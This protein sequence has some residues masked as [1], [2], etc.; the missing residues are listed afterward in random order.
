MK[1]GETLQQ[2]KTPDR[3]EQGLQERRGWPEKILGMHLLWAALSIIALTAILLPRAGSQL[4]DW[5]PGQVAT[6][7]VVMPMDVS[8]PDPEATDA[9]RE[10]ARESVLPVYDYEPKALVQL[11]EE[12]NSLF[13]ICRKPEGED[14]EFLSPV[15]RLLEGTQLSIE[16][17]MARVLIKSECSQELEKALQE[18]LLTLYSDRI[19]DDERAL[20]RRVAKKGLILRDLSTGKEI[21]ISPGDLDGIIDLRTELEGALRARLLEQGAVHR[22]WLRPII[23]FLNANIEANLFYDR[24]ETTERIRKAEESVTPRSQI[25][26]RGEILIRRGDRVG[27][28]QARVLQYLNRRRMDVSTYSNQAGIAGLVF[29][30]IA[31]WWKVSS[32]SGQVENRSRLSII[33]LLLVLFVGLNRLGLFL[34]EAVASSAGSSLLSDSRIYLWALPYASGAIT[35]NLLLGLQPALLFTASI[36]L[37]SGIMLG[38]SYQ[39]VVFAIGGGLVGALASQ[40]FKE[41]SAFSRVGVLIGLI[42][43][44]VILVLAL[45]AGWPEVWQKVGVE[46]IA[47]FFGGTFATG[48]ASLLLP[49]LENLAGIT[50]DIR[51]LELSNQNLPLL[52]RL[53]LEAPGTYQHSLAVGNL[54]EAGASAIGANSL[55]LRVCSYY[56]DVGKLVKPQYFVENQRGR[57]PHDSLLPSMSV[58]IIQSHVKEGLRLASQE[59][60][61]LPIRQGIATHHGTKLIRFFY[62]KALE[63][64]GDMDEKEKAKM[65]DIRES[66]YRYPGPKPHTKELGILLLADA[67]EAAARTIDSPTPGKIQGLVQK[68][69]SDAVDDGQLADSDLTFGEIDKI[70]SAFIWVL[71]N[72]YHS[73]IDYPGFDFNSPKGDPRRHETRRTADEETSAR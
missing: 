53:S 21:R 72:M 68:I 59:R 12:I 30:I 22:S 1:T 19:V 73:R 27:F 50:T 26:S 41:R 39:V 28:S 58:L 10:A 63:Q 45:W 51:L 37:L 24:A 5:E 48:I 32:R 47:G 54:A 40:Q 60:L 64:R 14:Q 49:I 13:Q 38:G 36:A 44:A 46:M 42:N 43:A 66:D 15:E 18:V 67:I 61:P 16:A 17:E 4:P 23:H 7:D 29:L 57:N 52:K 55:L 25:L 9:V 70:A 2:E 71:M 6:Y 3:I 34:A 8:L 20:E 62:T 65:G 56:H 11:S 31:A 35:I 69:I 33:F